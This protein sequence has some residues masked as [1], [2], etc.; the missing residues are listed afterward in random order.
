MKNKNITSGQRVRIWL[1]DV[2]ISND[3]C[4]PFEAIKLQNFL[5]YSTAVGSGSVSRQDSWEVF[6]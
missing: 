6:K 5:T 1:W 3:V 2:P 4:Y